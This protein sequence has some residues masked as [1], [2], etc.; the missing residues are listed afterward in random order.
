MASP[1]VVLQ[2]FAES[3]EAQE[4]YATRNRQRDEV[5]RDD[6]RPL[7]Q[8]FLDNEIGVDEFRSRVSGFARR[9]NLWGY[10]GFVGGMQFNK[11]VGAAPREEELAERVRDAIEPPADLDAARE[12]MDSF[13]EY[14]QRLK[15]NDLDFDPFPKST[16]FFLSY[17]WHIQQPTEWPI[18]YPTS[19]RYLDD[20]G[21][22]NTNEPYGT[23]YVS[24]VEILDDLRGEAREW[25]DEPVEYRDIANAIYWHEEH[26]SDDGGDDD[27]RAELPVHTEGENLY[28]PAVVADLDGIAAGDEAATARYADDDSDL[29]T[30]FER[31]CGHLFR[32]LGFDTEMLGQGTG[33]NP[34]GIAAAVRNDY[35]VIYDAKKR[36]NGYRLGRDDRAIREYI[37]THTR[38]LRDQGKRHIYF[39]VISSRFPDVD[40]SALREL[41]TSTDIDNV[42]LLTA[43]VLQQLLTLRLREPYLNLDDVKQVFANRSGSIRPEEL[44]NIVPGWRQEGEGFG[45][46]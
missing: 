37:E 24:F 1:E 38:R 35:A 21:L 11:L 4:H 8:E 43:D 19:E 42:V 40:E 17:F 7:I 14:T 36:E 10:N 29:G 25:L 9:H 3:D 45:G 46:T 26:E 18:F 20:E 23:R 33:R 41:R 12:T 27:T 13:A 2:Q 31:K 28:L 34:D 32:M 30:I 39:A 5:A 15:D 16:M 44:E 22:L 6:L